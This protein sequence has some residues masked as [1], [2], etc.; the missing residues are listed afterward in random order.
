MTNVET[1][2]VPPIETATDPVYSAEDLRQR[3]RAL[4]SP[5]G[6]DERLLWYAFMGSDRCLIKALHHMPIDAAPDRQVVDALMSTLHSVVTEVDGGLTVALLIT[7]RG[8]GGISPADQRWARALSESA[9][10]IGVPLE[11]LFRA[12]ATSLVQVA[13]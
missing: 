5:L 10:R 2:P 8:R 3:W 9:E 4:M 6:F 7:R 12:N 1:L 11:P 13:G